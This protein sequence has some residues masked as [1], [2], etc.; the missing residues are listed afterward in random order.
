MFLHD[1]CASPLYPWLCSTH[2]VGTVFTVSCRC[3]LVS[4][5]V[6]LYTYCIFVSYKE[7]LFGPLNW[8]VY[9]LIVSPPHA[10]CSSCP[11]WWWPHPWPDDIRSNLVI[12]RISVRTVVGVVP[13]EERWLW[14]LSREWGGAFH[15]THQHPLGCWLIVLA[16][17]EETGWCEHTH[18]PL[19]AHSSVKA[20]LVIIPWAKP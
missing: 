16:A 3:I 9:L 13:V 18:W 14:E 17:L 11:G 7:I 2:S 1:K 15:S 19:G 20:H 10:S 5:D 12:A 6:Y 8:A 4:L